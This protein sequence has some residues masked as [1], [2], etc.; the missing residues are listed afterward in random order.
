MPFS[1]V[2]VET[3]HHPSRDA[4]TPAAVGIGHD[5]TVANTEEGDGYQPHCV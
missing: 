1:S 3:H 2:C 5:I 4:N